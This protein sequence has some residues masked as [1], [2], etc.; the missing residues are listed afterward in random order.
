MTD[1]SFSFPHVSV[2]RTVYPPQEDS[3]LLARAAFHNARGKILD[4]GC[5]TGI[6][7]IT[8]TMNGN[9]ERVVFADLNDAAV[10]A[11]KDNS[12]TLATP[13]DFV[14]TDIFENLKGKFDTILFNPPYLPTANDEKLNDE[15]NLAYD[16]GLD[17]RETIDRF[18]QSFNNHLAPNGKLLLVQSSLNDLEKTRKTLQE[19]GFVIELVG[20]ASFFFER[21]E[22]WKVRRERENETF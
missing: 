2:P 12:S 8:A 19:K 21:V 22:V 16:G 5:G 18:L 9:V 11:A 10:H 20:S 17:G 14:K 3:L 7:G 6:A 1:R 13:C 15:E 4:L